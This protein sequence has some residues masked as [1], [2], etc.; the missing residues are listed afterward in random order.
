M[1]DIT[2]FNDTNHRI[3]SASAAFQK[4][5][6]H[7]FMLRHRETSDYYAQIL[8]AYQSLF[9][10]CLTQLLLDM[11]HQLKSKD[12]PVRLRKLCW[13]R[14]NPTRKELD[15]AAI[16]THSVFE[17]GRWEGVKV[18]HPLRNVSKAAV[19]LY[20]RV[21]DA[22]HNL[23]YRPFMLDGPFWEDCTLLDLL[24]IVPKADE[25]EQAYREFARAMMEW[26]TIEREETAKWIKSLTDT[27]IGSA[28]H[29][30][31]ST[32][33]NNTIRLRCAGYFLQM[34]FT[35]YED[36]RDNRPTETLLLTYARMMNPGDEELLKSI[37][38][39]RN[40]LLDLQKMLPSITALKEW[41][42]GQR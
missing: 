5:I 34:L 23:I 9:Q 16:V 20:K 29:L 25:V 14:E 32:D 40:Q 31:K 17:N 11:D 41:R 18:G 13:D 26:N 12:I 28:V 3:A 37:K 27:S 36:R 21:V 6:Y 8:R 2:D 15:P 19:K 4:G 35:V 10:L 38:E 24:S 22:R 1:N 33:K 7:L 42:A 39:Y 30:E